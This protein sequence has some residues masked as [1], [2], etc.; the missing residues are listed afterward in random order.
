[1]AETYLRVN[2]NELLFVGLECNCGNQEVFDAQRRPAQTVIVKCEKC[3][4]TIPRA[5]DVLLLVRRVVEDLRAVNGF[6][7]LRGN[8]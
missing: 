3:G 8:G 2:A 6:L 5:E 4:E 1:M 7:I